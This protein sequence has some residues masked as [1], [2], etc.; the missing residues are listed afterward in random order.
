[1]YY[2]VKLVNVCVDF[3]LQSVIEEN[4]VNVNMKAVSFE[5]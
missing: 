4:G 3:Y 2:G 5:S 1:M